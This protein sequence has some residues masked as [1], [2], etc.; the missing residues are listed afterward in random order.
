MCGLAWLLQGPASKCQY[1]YVSQGLPGLGLGGPGGDALRS[2]ETKMRL[3]QLQ[4]HLQ[5]GKKVP[6]IYF[7]DAVETATLR[8]PPHGAPGPVA[9]Q[10]PS[11]MGSHVGCAHGWEGEETQG[12]T[13]AKC[14]E[15]FLYSL[16]GRGGQECA[17]AWSPGVFW[18]R[19]LCLP[20]ADGEFWC[21]SHTDQTPIFGQR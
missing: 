12:R 21:C 14:S 17:L 20:Y 6:L 1:L 10:P 5:P 18:F 13:A 4:K 2:Q 16:G 3:T 15:E 19:V 9:G 11:S 8:A 7:R